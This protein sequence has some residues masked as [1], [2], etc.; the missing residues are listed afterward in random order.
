MICLAS[1]LV[2]WRMVKCLEPWEL[3]LF[4]RLCTLKIHGQQAWY[5]MQLLESWANRV[6]CATSII[7][8][9][10]QNWESRMAPFHLVKISCIVRV[11]LSYKPGNLSFTGAIAKRHVSLTWTFWGGHFPVP[12]MRCQ[13]GVQSK[14][15]QVLFHLSLL[16]WYG[17]ETRAARAINKR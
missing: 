14:A 15:R 6:G 10:G 3:G 12:G 2:S 7:L 9:V 8:H 5:E 16:L 4:L 11:S 13:I 1:F 17:K